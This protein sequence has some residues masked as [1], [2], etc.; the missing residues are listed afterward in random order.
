MAQFPFDQE[1]RPPC[2]RG[3][4]SQHLIVLWIGP[5][6]GNAREVYNGPGAPV[7]EVCGKFASNGT[8]PISLSTLKRIAAQ[9]PR[10]QR[11][12][13]INPVDGDQANSRTDDL[14]E[15]DSGMFKKNNTNGTNA[16]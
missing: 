4:N 3:S 9:V 6:T 2:S 11:L 13:Q 12:A 1:V 7:W 5:N 8:R 10:Y 15:G 14:G 16:L